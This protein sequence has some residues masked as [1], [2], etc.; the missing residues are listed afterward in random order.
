[1]Q[2]GRQA[3]V[4]EDSVRMRVC[5][6]RLSARKRLCRFALTYWLSKHAVKKR[7][8]QQPHSL[9]SFDKY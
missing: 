5:V 3:K 4:R 6:L 9:L 2:A 1:M 8:E 7:E